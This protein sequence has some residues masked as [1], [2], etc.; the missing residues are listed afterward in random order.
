[1][2]LKVLEGRSDVS[3]DVSSDSY[4]LKT[5]RQ[6]VLGLKRRGKWEEIPNGR[7]ICPIF[8]K[9]GPMAASTPYL[10]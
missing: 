3:S 4:T 9:R 8:G 1:M 10:A 6:L 2:R 5:F 7:T